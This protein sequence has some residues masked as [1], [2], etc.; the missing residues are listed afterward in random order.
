MHRKIIPH[1]IQ[2]SNVH[3]LNPDQNVLE[4]AKLLTEK[5][6]GALLVMKD[7]TLL[8][9]FTERDLAQRVVA[10]GLE[11]HT[12]KISDVM[13]PDPMTV[14]PHDTAESVLKKMQTTGCRH[15]PVKE[16]A[17]VVGMVSIRDLY[18]CVI[19]DLEEDVHHMDAYIHDAG[20]GKSG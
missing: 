7:D 17:F 14:H 3:R 6:I 8:G 13:T 9:I 5:N 16:G 19:K 15:M 4:A 20:Y 11:P 2:K 10:K 1:V 18:A 12:T